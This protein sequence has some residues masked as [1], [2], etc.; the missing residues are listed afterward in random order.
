MRA[1][2][3]GTR[4][5]LEVFLGASIMTADESSTILHL[6]V[7]CPLVS[8]E[9]IIRSEAIRAST[10]IRICAQVRLLMPL[11]VLTTVLVS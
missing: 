5:K 9:V 2:V 11:E 4:P 10:A 3:V 8:D 7:N 1:K 6:A